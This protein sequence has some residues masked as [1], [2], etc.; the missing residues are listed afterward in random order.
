LENRTSAAIAAPALKAYVVAKATTY[1]DSRILTESFKP[2]LAEIT[3]KPKAARFVPK[4]V[5]RSGR[6][7]TLA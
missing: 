1:K 6:Y 4:G 2:R 5:G 7:K 3:E